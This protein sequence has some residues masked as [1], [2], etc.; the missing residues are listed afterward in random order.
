MG[1][2]KKYM[3]ILVKHGDFNIRFYACRAGRGRT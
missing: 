3:G 2:S 1:R